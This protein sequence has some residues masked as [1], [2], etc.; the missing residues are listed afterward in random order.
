MRKDRESAEEE[1]KKAAQ[2]SALESETCQ[3]VHSD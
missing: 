1:K 2:G 3:R